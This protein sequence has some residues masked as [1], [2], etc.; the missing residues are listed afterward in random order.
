MRVKRILP[1]GDVVI[2]SRG[3]R[4]IVDETKAYQEFISAEHADEVVAAFNDCFADGSQ[5]REA[6]T[7]AESYRRGIR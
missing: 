3:L 1:S 2:S 6:I 4:R 5:K 7:Y